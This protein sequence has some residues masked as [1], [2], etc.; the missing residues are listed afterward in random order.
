M[1][2]LST[3]VVY[4]VLF[5]W[6]LANLGDQNPFIIAW[7]LSLPWFGA[8]FARFIFLRIDAAINALLN[9]HRVLKTSMDRDAVLSA[10][11]KTVNEY[12][13]RSTRFRFTNEDESSG[14]LSARW[15]LRV[16]WLRFLLFLFPWEMSLYNQ[17]VDVTVDIEVTGMSELESEVDIRFSNEADPQFLDW[18]GYAVRVQMLA[19][20]QNAIQCERTVL[21]TD[22][23][24]EF[25][26]YDQVTNLLF[27]GRA[28]Y[29]SGKFK[30]A[31]KWFKNATL[32]KP[33]RADTWRWVA[34]TQESLE[35]ND[36]A[37]ASYEKALALDPS[38]E[39]LWLDYAA[40]L[41]K[42]GLS[43]KAAEAFPAAFAAGLDEVAAG[44]YLPP[45]LPEKFWQ[46]SAAPKAKRQSAGSTYSFV[47]S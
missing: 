32:L 46:E 42:Q 38:M 6:Q 5:S 9:N 34:K 3:I 41:E 28:H 12:S 35:R 43:E 8:L 47:G 19:L 36:D 13:Y 26:R 24:K 21:L 23:R 22:P 1:V 29:N 11:T 20:I 15:S 2:Q 44:V 37:L 17:T 18:F 25:S 31:L 10:V 16:D 45:T 39:V 27:E 33:D 40:L 7:N 14:Q 30:R 4:V